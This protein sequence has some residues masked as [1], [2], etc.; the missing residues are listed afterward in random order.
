[1]YVAGPYTA[2]D[3]AGLVANTEAAMYA[4]LE[5]LARGHTPFIPHLTHYFDLYV[6]NRLGHRLPAEVYYQWD[7]ALLDRCDA[8]LYLG[9]SPG[10][11]R[12]LARAQELELTVFYSVK[13]IPFA[14]L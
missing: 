13:E 4:G 12:E 2:P 5:V 9:P 7:L 10:A 14:D 8:L 11:D 6:K 1:M 3:D